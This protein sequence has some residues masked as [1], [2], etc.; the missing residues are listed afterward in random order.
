MNDSCNVIVK[1]CDK[2]QE[3]QF[4]FL[5]FLLYSSRLKARDKGQFGNYRKV[6]MIVNFCLKIENGAVRISV[7]RGKEKE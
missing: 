7:R 4:S 2:K 1:Y 6:I 5:F 3:C